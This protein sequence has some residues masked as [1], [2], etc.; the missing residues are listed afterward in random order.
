MKI[1]KKIVI[2]FVFYASPLVL[3]CYLFLGLIETRI[4]TDF[5]NLHFWAGLPILLWT[6]ITFFLTLSMFFSKKLRNDVL[7]RL[8]GIKERDEREVQIVG[9]ALKSTYLTTMTLLLFL[10]FFSLFY[11]HVGK[12]ASGSVGGDEPPIEVC[13]KMEYHL[14]DANT[15]VTQKQGFDKYFEM[16]DLPISSSTLILI[17][18]LWQIFSYRHVSRMSFK[19]SET[20][21][22]C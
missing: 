1:L 8:S 11:I 9:N 15:V 2:N 7:V 20:D 18:L 4:T 22:D 21:I 5:D 3:V 10:L 13:L 14:I 17:L 16:N 12:K 6:P 19:L